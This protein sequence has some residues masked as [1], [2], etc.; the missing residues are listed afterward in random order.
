[1]HSGFLAEHNAFCEPKRRRVVKS[2][3]TLLVVGGASD[4]RFPLSLGE[5][6]S[7]GILAG[8]PPKRR[9]S[10]MPSRAANAQVSWFVIVGRRV[11]H[12]PLLHVGSWVWVGEGVEFNFSKNK[13]LWGLLIPDQ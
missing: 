12:M 1:V 9:V 8:S 10:T 3:T 13:S 6:G 5:P 11:P 4:W 2:V 7:A